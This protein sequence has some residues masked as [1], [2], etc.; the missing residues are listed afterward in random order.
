MFARQYGGAMYGI[1]A[2]NS[3]AL[4]IDIDLIGFVEPC[5]IGS[6]LPIV[7]QLER[8]I[9]REKFAQMLIF[10]VT[11]AVSI[12][13]NTKSWRRRFVAAATGRCDGLAVGR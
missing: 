6:T 9:G 7:K 1:S 8:R 5:S 12:G 10:A 4:P 13:L 2:S 11:R 3:V